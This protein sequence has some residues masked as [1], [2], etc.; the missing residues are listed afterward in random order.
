M[1]LG[2]IPGQVRF[3]TD[4]ASSIEFTSLILG[5]IFE[6]YQPKKGFCK[7]FDQVFFKEKQIWC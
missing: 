5:F 4:V 1:N 2:R 6:V 3:I 7:D